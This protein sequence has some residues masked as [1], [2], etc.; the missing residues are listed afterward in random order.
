MKSKTGHKWTYLWKK[1]RLTDIEN[2]LVVEKEE[3]NI[4]SWI[5][6][7]R[8]DAEAPILWPPDAK[9]WLIGKDPD[10]GKDWK[11]EEKGTTEDEMVEWHHRLD[12][13]ELEKAPEIWWTRK[14]GVLLRSMGHKESDVTEQRNWTEKLETTLQGNHTSMKLKKNKTSCLLKVLENLLRGT[15]KYHLFYIFIVP[16]NASA[17]YYVEPCHSVLHVSSFH[18]FLSMFLH[19]ENCTIPSNIS[20]GSLIL[21][22]VV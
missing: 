13:R 20:Y 1:N 18:I 15:F 21:C 14:P 2:R 12:G 10:A 16:L 7:G 4:Q 9:N 17:I 3:G 6:I 11:Q 8:T 22:S 5:F 19:D